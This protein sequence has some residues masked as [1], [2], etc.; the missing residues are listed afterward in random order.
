MTLPG[1]TK[2]LVEEDEGWGLEVECVS[3]MTAKEYAKR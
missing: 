2:D 3:E 1:L